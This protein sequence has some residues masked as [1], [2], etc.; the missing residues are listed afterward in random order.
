MVLAMDLLPSWSKGFHR[1]NRTLC[2]VLTSWHDGFLSFMRAWIGDRP[3][4]FALGL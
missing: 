2:T 3:L 4:A 1:E